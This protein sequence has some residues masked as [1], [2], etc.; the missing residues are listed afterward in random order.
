MGWFD[1]QI[2]DRIRSDNEAFE[3]SFVRAAG[4]IMGSRLS[5]AMND[6]RQ[7]ATDAIGEILK[8]YHIKPREV[9]DSITDMNDTLEYLMRPHGIMRRNVFPDRQR[10]RGVKE[11]HRGFELVFSEKTQTVSRSE[12]LFRGMGSHD[13]SFS[14]GFQRKGGPASLCADPPV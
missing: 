3:D 5:A 8:A 9:P 12:N 7:A 6:Q 10:Q 13:S 1:E 11:D 4:I 14:G 2:K